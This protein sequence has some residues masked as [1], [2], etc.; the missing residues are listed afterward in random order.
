MAKKL[1][2]DWLEQSERE[3][4]DE[5]RRSLYLGERV[6]GTVTKGRQEYKV[7]IVDISPLGLAFIGS[8][9]HLELPFQVGDKIKL[10]FSKKLPNCTITAEI[11]NRGEMWIQ[12]SRRQ[13]FGVKF[14]INNWERYADFSKALPHKLIS[15]KTYIRPQITCQDPF[16]FKEMVLFQCNG[17]TANGI[18]LVC[19]SRWKTILPGQ[20]MD[21]TI[22]VPGKGEFKVR[23]KNSLHF[24]QSQWKDRFRIYLEYVDPDPEFQ[25]SI[26]EYLV[27]MNS[28]VTPA[29][30]RKMQFQFRN[31]ET[32]F[33]LEKV[34]YSEESF[35]PR[36]FSPTGIGCFNGKKPN[37]TLIKE[38]SR[39]LA[40]KLGANRVSY[41]NLV[42]FLGKKGE[43]KVHKLQEAL[44][45]HVIESDHVVLTNLIVSKKA[46]LSDFFLPLLQQT[47][48]ITAQAK[49]KY[50][51]IEVDED[52]VKIVKKMGFQQI[53]SGKDSEVNTRIVALEVNTVLSNHHWQLDTN[54]WK[55]LYGEL[56]AFLGRVPPKK[57][58]SV[59]TYNFPKK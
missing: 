34:R 11:A 56:N 8:R 15:C 50:L 7:E 53:S 52:F 45:D 1:Q 9:K 20:V 54:V 30:L 19:S 38:F 29:I 46:L 59:M 16:F 14:E 27:M 18:D 25:H 35:P 13:R 12:K 5:C 37:P 41:F 51:V 23:A 36:E 4:R 58:T 47:I 2:D 3:N 24:Y 17:F 26:A 32:A 44:P 33:H 6:H 28:D 43:E 48:R 55:K 10:E 31:F 40:C 22:Y 21:L 39:E 42:F 49:A 57:Q